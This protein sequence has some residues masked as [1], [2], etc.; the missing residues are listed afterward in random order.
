MVYRDEFTFSEGKSSGKARAETGRGVTLSD[1][2]ELQALVRSGSGA[3]AV[4][5]EAILLWSEGHAKT[6]IGEKIGVTRQTVAQWIRNYKEG[7]AERLRD[8]HRSGRPIVYGEDCIEEIVRVATTS[9]SELGLSIKQWSIRK[10]E[11][12]LNEECGYM[13]KR[14]RI[15]QVLHEQGVSLSKTKGKDSDEV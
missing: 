9:P 1:L 10:L 3:M 8:E 11:R 6:E 5:A 13:I 2:A 4:R 15:C 14:S 12:Y 7:G